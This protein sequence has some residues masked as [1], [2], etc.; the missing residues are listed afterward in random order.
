MKSDLKNAT[1]ALYN[2]LSSVHL[3]L[4]DFTKKY[5]K[6]VFLFY[7]LGLTIVKLR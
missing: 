6:V 3:R 2:T 7:P 5:L 1:I 4:E